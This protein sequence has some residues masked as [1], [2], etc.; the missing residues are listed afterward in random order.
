LRVKQLRLVLACG[1]LAAGA[2]TADAQIYAWHDARGTLVLSDRPA[3]EGVRSYEV[4]GSASVRTTTPL[5]RRRS[6]EFDP[7]IDQH[8]RLHGVRPDLVRAVIQVESAFN[9]RARSPKGAMGLMQ[10]MPA[11]AAEMGVA[12]AY[13]PFEN[14]RGGVAYLR[15]LLTRYDENEELALAAYNAGP[16]AVERYGYRVPPYAETRNYVSRIRTATD[17]ADAR[18]SGRRIYKVVKNV[19]GRSIA[20]YSNIDPSARPTTD[21]SSAAATMIAALG[22]AAR[23]GIQPVLP[24]DALPAEAG[25]LAQES[26]LE[27]PLRA[28][29]AP[30]AR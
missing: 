5:D 14:I 21:R 15:S 30:R 28:L 16:A 12:D 7:L 9:P 8:A 10:L 26:A 2:R 18:A 4:T 17:P 13:D 1:I 27:D 19:D 20:T 23:H 29:R 3:G 22:S 25:R 11:T 24:A 6:S